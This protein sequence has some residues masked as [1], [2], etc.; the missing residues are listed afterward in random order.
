MLKKMSKL[1]YICLPNSKE[2]GIR[3]NDKKRKENVEYSLFQTMLA[4][5]MHHFDDN[6]FIRTQN[7]GII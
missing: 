3:G 4:A 2:N 6:F 7:L 5:V 1:L